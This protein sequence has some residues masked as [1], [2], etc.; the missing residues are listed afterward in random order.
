MSGAIYSDAWYRIAQARV[1]LLPGVKTSR[2]SYRGLPWVV[3]EDAYAHRFFRITPEAHNFLLTLHQGVTVD[4]AWQSYL[5]QH[6]EHAPGQEEVVQLLS[7][8]HVSNLLHFSDSANSVEIDRR[9]GEARS[10]ELRSK[11]MS[12]LYFR[13][14][15]WD[16]DDFLS[17]ADRRLRLLPSWLLVAVWLAVGLAG[18]WAVVGEWGRVSDR[19]QGAFAWANLPLL[20]LCMAVMKVVHEI[21]HGLVCK[22]YGGKVHTFGLMFLVTT[23]LPYVDTTASWAFPNKWDR[24]LVSSA[25]ML[26]DLFMAA[27]GALVWANTGP[28]LVNSLAFNVMLIGSVSSLV[29]NGNPLLRFDAYYVLADALDIP[30][31]YQKSQQYWFFLADRYLLGSH[32]ARTPVDV[33]SERKWLMAYAPVS[34]VYRLLV[35]YAIVLFV[36]DLWLGLGLVILVLTFYM[37]VAAPAWKGLSHLL[38]PQVQAHRWRAWAGAGGL[39]A[40]VAA[41]VFAVPWSHAIQAQGVVQMSR[42]SVLYAPLDARLQRAVLGH[43]QTVEAGTPLMWF[44]PAALVLDIEQTER[45]RDELLAMERAALSRTAADLQPLSEQ[46]L[47]KEQRLLDLRRRLSQ[48]VVRAPHAGRY[49]ALDSGERQGAWMGQ[50]TEIGHVLDPS[51]GYQFVA[52][53]SQERARELFAQP[54]GHLGLRLLGQADQLIAVDR[55][56]LVP[57][58]MDRLPSAALGWLGGGDLA[59]SNQ[60]AKGD[61]AAEEFF[62]LRLTLKPDPAAH[63]VLAHGMRGVL[64]LELPPRSLYA[65]INES[66]R[67]LVQKRYRLG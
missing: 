15:I 11:L 60:D 47:A 54:V 21:C 67:Q 9:A 49:I 44:D 3:L 19:T 2:Q 12:F 46:R 36:M 18:T 62:E 43:G 64:R 66:L 6:P 28:G 10:K 63:V 51:E 41:L 23:P 7:Q 30:N 56:V 34:L 57:Y 55:V 1:S 24:V 4:E 39:G 35:S 52:V 33:P 45:E 38:G 27:L 17:A 13:V 61:K 58:Q 42:F 53:V 20:Y 65:R 16:P 48:A 8:L 59:V 22:R 32:A 29:F 26:A 5:R 37:L 31:F 40:L 25:G 50:G 14:P